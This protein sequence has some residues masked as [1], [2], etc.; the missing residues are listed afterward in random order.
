M[1]SSAKSKL[2]HQIS[3]EEQPDYGA[4][5]DGEDGE[6]YDLYVLGFDAMGDSCA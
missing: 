3:V 4:T 1:V 2:Q 5:E 6:D